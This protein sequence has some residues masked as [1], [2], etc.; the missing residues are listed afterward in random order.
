M[1][2]YSKNPN[3]CGPITQLQKT[4]S[5]CWKKPTPT[6][7]KYSIYKGTNSAPL[8]SLSLQ[9]RT[10]NRIPCVSTCYQFQNLIA[11][12]KRVSSSVLLHKTIQLRHSR[13]RS[14][15]WIQTLVSNREPQKISPHN[16]P[17]VK[18]CCSKQLTYFQAVV[19]SFE[20]S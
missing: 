6:C 9:C 20:A 15:G 7:F 2:F 11:I 1:K 17:T 12:E 8:D 14:V 18:L 10:I 16:S 3:V 5:D 19:L 13:K 4:A